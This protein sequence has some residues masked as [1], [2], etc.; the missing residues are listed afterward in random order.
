MKSINVKKILRTFLLVL[1]G[2]AVL[3]TFYFLW[4]KSQPVI[5][6]YEIVTPKLD[7]VVTKTVAT[8]NVEPRFEVL[9]KPQISGI[10]AELNKEAG[11]MV[12]RA[13]LLQK[14]RLY[15]KWFSLTVPNHALKLRKL[16]CRR[17]KR[18]IKETNNCIPRV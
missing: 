1:V 8:G 11:Q 16:R 7:T 5:T 6:Q 2:V 9:I 4:K 15:R 14:S 18:P 13:R 3:S 10:V 17:L 12:K